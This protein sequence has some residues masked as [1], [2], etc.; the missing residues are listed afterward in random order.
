MLYFC[1]VRSN[2]SNGLHSLALS[3]SIT[4]KSHRNNT[5]C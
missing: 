4:Y 2:V 5:G 3:T 1:F